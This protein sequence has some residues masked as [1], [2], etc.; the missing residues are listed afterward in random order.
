MRGRAGLALLAAAACR[1][2]VS[3]PVNEP[4]PEVAFAGC[5]E[6]RTGP[7]CALDA[8]R[9]LRVWIP[10]RE[11]VRASAA[12]EMLAATS[13]VVEGGTRLT[14][15][16]PERADALEVATDRWKWK[17]A[18][19]SEETSPV[20]DEAD[21]LRS[22]G[23]IDEAVKLLE[24]RMASLTPTLRTRALGL[25]ARAELQRNR[26][27]LAEV[28]FAEARESAI[29]HGQ[30]SELVRNGQARAYWMIRNEHRF[31]EARAL[32]AGLDA[33]ADA[34]ARVENVYYAG[35]IGYFTGDLRTAL[36]LFDEAAR[37]AVRLGM[38]RYLR[39]IHQADANV[40]IAT[41]RIEE[42]LRLLSSISGEMTSCERSIWVNNLGWVSLLLEREAVAEDHFRRALAIF[43]GECP[44]PARA[45]NVL[46]NLGLLA[47][48][49][50]DVE[51][52]KKHLE[53]ARQAMPR[54][55]LLVLLEGDDLEGRLALRAHQPKQAKQIYDR[56]LRLAEASLHSEMRWRALMGRGLAFL[57]KRRFEQAAEAFEQAEEALDREQ[58]LVPV[59]AGRG[60]FLASRQESSRLLIDLLVRSGRAPRAL[61]VLRRAR[62]RVL[63]N[64]MRADRVAGMPDDLRARWEEALARYARER[65]ALE[66]DI[67]EDWKLAESTL[68]EKQREREERKVRLRAA[69]DDAFAM[70]PSQQADY[71]APAEGGLLLAYYPLD[72][73]WIG[74]AAAGA[75]V[76]AQK[77]GRID[78]NLE[79]EALSHALLDPFAAEIDRAE[80]ISI[81][82]YGSLRDVDFH[83]LPWKGDVL[84]AHAPITYGFDLPDPSEAP[85]TAD[86]ALVVGDP[87]SDLSGAQAEAEGVVAALERAKKWKVATIRGEAA[88]RR[89]VLDGIAEARL[90]H[91]AGHGEVGGR[92][93]W[94]S[95][96]PL[97]QSQRLA[98]ADL[99][100][101]P[102]VPEIAVLSGCET[103]R[104]GDRSALPGLGL[105]QAFL[106]AGSRTVVAASRPIQDEAA[107]HLSRALYEG[108]E[109][110]LAQGLKRA[111]LSLRRTH[112]KADW[113]AF[114]VLVRE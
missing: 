2:D 66:A 24:E 75:R 88:T 77:L 74:F 16:I 100:T 112:P 99:F 68:A 103:A 113:A 108:G 29:A 83:A 48:K 63:S 36:R 91:Y 70:I 52:A 42:A 111:Q 19:G 95:G 84:L 101:L 10:G 102:R 81:M 40:L 94:E 93:G 109:Q 60:S 44:N 82:S 51:N 11:A 57:A 18:L 14:L 96:L 72:D 49:R 53:R 5:A 62:A 27:E 55:D 98:V 4:A 50:G 54:P 46:I 32:L 3:P 64:L 87:R 37:G 15:Q 38:S 20:L 69:L 106:A 80:R 59:D 90:F 9:T 25:I 105:A 30:R 107:V 65:D 41:G 34:E 21:R 17:L 33:S 35:L 85:N 56:L 13:S 7:I 110:D 39:A 97:A 76:R 89:A 26:P 104:D 8:K 28:R 12:G 1:T 45:G 58:L 92:A 114:R 22:A 43:E 31:S 73:G 78:G 67:A 79:K 86:V 61:E 47:M 71:D 23:K 6:I